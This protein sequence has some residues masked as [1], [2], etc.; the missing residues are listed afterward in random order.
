MQILNDTYTV[1]FGSV[2]NECDG[3]SSEFSKAEDDISEALFIPTTHILYHLTEEMFQHSIQQLNTQLN[4]WRVIFCEDYVQSHDHSLQQ[5]QGHL[6][7]SSSWCLHISLA[8]PQTPSVSSFSHSSLLSPDLTDNILPFPPSIFFNFFFS[9]HLLLSVWHTFKLVNMLSVTSW[10][11][12]QSQRH[13]QRQEWWPRMNHP[14]YVTEIHK[15]K[16]LTA[17][18]RR[19]IQ[20]D[21]PFVHTSLVTRWL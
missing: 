3:L 17:R 6:S 21:F 7:F 8:L 11:L 14:V 12:I 5:E 19:I 15:S 9:L 4:L 10:E 13:T 20:K 2:M 1:L 18:D 16:Q